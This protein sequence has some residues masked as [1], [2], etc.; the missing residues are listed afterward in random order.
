MQ[1][2]ETFTTD[3][4]T[5][6]NLSY[7]TL[8]AEIVETLKSG[9]KNSNHP[10]Q[11]N[12]TNVLTTFKSAHRTM[13]KDLK[14]EKKSGKVKTKTLTWPTVMLVITNQCY[15]YLNTSNFQKIV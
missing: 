3:T 15:N 8:T 9:S 7:I 6:N 14:D 10:L 12:E 13:T 5:V 2:C 1:K 11:V 4:E